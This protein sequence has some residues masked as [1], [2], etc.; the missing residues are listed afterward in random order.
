MK[1]EHKKAIQYLKDNLYHNNTPEVLRKRYVV[2]ASGYNIP[3]IIVFDFRNDNRVDIW[4][5][6]EKDNNYTRKYDVWV[7]EELQP[8]KKILE[9]NKTKI[10]VMP[11][12]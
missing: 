12:E 1:T 10:V 3:L 5:W 8:L 11:D 6:S 7:A 2:Q 9:K 4:I